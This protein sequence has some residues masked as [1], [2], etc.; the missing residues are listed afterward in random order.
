[1]AGA[2]GTSGANGSAN[3]LMNKLLQMQAQLQTATPPQSIATA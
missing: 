2:N 3:D 1:V